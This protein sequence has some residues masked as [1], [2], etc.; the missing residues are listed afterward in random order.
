MSDVFK[1]AKQVK[2]ESM[3][4]FVTRLRSLAE[5]RTFL[6][7]SEAVKDQFIYSWGSKKL[8]KKLSREKEI[9]LE[10]CI[11]IVKW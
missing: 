10:K 4:N 8:R 3:I 6:S 1:R 9:T 2:D 7:M 5:T 11:E